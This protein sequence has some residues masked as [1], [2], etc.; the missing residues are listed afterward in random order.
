MSWE[1]QGLLGDPGLRMAA[2][3]T[4]HSNVRKASFI[5]AFHSICKEFHPSSQRAA[6]LADSWLHGRSSGTHHTLPLWTG[7]DLHGS[8]PVPADFHI[9]T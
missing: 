9:V 5:L 7:W 6:G 2:A 4:P 3:S 8:S 1:P